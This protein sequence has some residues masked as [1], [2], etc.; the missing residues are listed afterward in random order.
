MN[1]LDRVIEICETQAELARRVKERGHPA[2]KQQH[3]WNW[4]HRAGGVVPAE[5]CLAVEDSVDGEVT[6]YDL[7]PDVYGP[8]PTPISGNGEIAQSA[9]ET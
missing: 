2:L 5:Y 3:I 6:R 4:I 9:A 1:A 8:A 7:R